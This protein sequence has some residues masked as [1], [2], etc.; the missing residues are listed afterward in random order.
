MCTQ[1][2]SPYNVM[3]SCSLINCNWLL[4][5]GIRVCCGMN[6][7]G[8]MVMLELQTMC[9]C[10]P[11]L[12]FFHSEKWVWAVLYQLCEWEATADLHWAH[13]ESRTGGVCAR[14]HQVVPY[15]LLQQQNC[16]WA[17]WEQGTYW[18]HNYTQN[19]LCS[20]HFVNAAVVLVHFSENFCQVRNREA[21]KQRAILMVCICMYVL[22]MLRTVVYQRTR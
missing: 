20:D 10:I 15:W 2:G 18:F 14:R 16:L 5:Y 11:C 1:S 9:E 13:T 7:W 12:T 22:V 8:L 21:L 4:L 17:D 3:H 19:K 6:T